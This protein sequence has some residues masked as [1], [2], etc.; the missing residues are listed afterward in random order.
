MAELIAGVFAD[1]GHQG[2]VAHGDDGLDELTT[3]TTSTVPP[4]SLDKTG[5]KV[6]TPVTA[7]ATVL[8]TTTAPEVSDCCAETTAPGCAVP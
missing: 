1:R 4:T 5:D 2:L 6:N 7:S 8:L 3:T